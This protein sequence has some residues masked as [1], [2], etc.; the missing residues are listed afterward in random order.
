[1]DTDKSVKQTR[2]CDELMALGI[3]DGD[4]WNYLERRPEA[5]L[6]EYESSGLSAV[7]YLNFR[8]I[9]RMRRNIVFMGITLIICISSSIAAFIILNLI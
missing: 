2:L 8:N 4:L 7:D 3:K 1:M 9:R 6:N 5:F